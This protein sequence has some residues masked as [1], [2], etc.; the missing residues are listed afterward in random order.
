MTDALARYELADN[1]ATITMDDGKA[2]ALSPTMIEQLQAALDRARTE[3]AGA[4]VLAGRPDKFCAGFDLRIMMSGPDNAIALLRQG[5]DLL[6]RLF[7]LPVPLVIACTGHA[8]AGGSLVVLTGDTRICADGAYKVGLNEVAIGLPV[9]VL[10]M[11]LARARLSPQELTRATL[12]ANIYTPTDARAAGWFDAVVPAGD[13]AAAA[14]AEAVRLAAL[15]KAAFLGTK[16]R[17]RS[18]TI[19][20]IRTT[21]DD[22]VR[23]A[24]NR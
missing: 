4:V 22:D 3:N 17:L 11:E 6:L 23:G 15:P 7:E 10:A 9:P 2:N 19:N 18:A 16:A 12:L 14:K 20:H 8:L 13:V 1:V 24:L 5:G 21:F